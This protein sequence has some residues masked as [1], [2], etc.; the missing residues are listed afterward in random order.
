MAAHNF[1]NL[2]TGFSKAT[3][4]LPRVDTKYVQLD[5]FLNPNAQLYGF[6]GGRGGLE[7][8]L[9][10]Q[11]DYRDFA[12]YTELT[13]KVSSTGALVYY[14]YE[15]GLMKRSVKIATIVAGSTEAIVTFTLDADSYTNVGSINGAVDRSPLK[16][17]D[18]IMTRG[19]ISGLIVDKSG[20][21]QATQYVAIRRDNVSDTLLTELQY[22]LSNSI[23][24]ISYSVASS[25]GSKSPEE[26][27]NTPMF[28]LRNQVQTFRS[29]DTITGDL[30]TVTFKGPQGETKLIDRTRLLQEWMHR[31]DVNRAMILSPGGQFTIPGTGPGT[32]LTRLTTGLLPGVRAYGATFEYDAV[33]GYTAAD[34]DALDAQAKAN[35]AGS[36]FT[37][38]EGYKH[39]SA[40]QK[41]ILAEIGGG[42]AAIDYTAL[43]TGDAKQKAIDLG[44]RSVATA[45][46][47]T[48]HRQEA[49]FF[50]EPEVTAVAGYRYN[51]LALFVPGM[52]QQVMADDENGRR[53]KL[54]VPSMRILHTTTSDGQDRRY[55]TFT[56]GGLEVNGVDE[57]NLET[58]TQQGIQVVNLRNFMVS[59]PG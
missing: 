16:K 28:R 6:L 33:G 43:G 53:R 4:S 56:P 54:I 1:T 38:F 25:E 5:D 10:M 39:G 24:L 27:S 9:N 23:R 51:S 41:G 50:N 47:I 44:F 13:G 45:N 21:G 17:G 34:I 37:V 22:H 11:F 36:S 46:G 7:T 26:G 30:D 32:G 14:D 59:Q 52:N 57:R 20:S 8:A 40:F 48:Y 18:T 29:K 42:I 2:G 31:L 35:Y 3:V 12:D 19:E 49:S 15:T 58:F 55:Y